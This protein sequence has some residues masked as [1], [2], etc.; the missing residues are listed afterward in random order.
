MKEEMKLMRKQGMSYQEIGQVCGVSKDIVR[1]HLIKKVRLSHKIIARRWQEKNMNKIKIRKRN[2]KYQEYNNQYIKDRYHSDPEFRKKF[3]QI[4]KKSQKK[5]KRI[6]TKKG[7]CLKCGKKKDK[8]FVKCGKC[9]KKL[10]LREV[11]K[12]QKK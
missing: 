8:R 2:K 11:E 6:R 9:R 5:S 4:V 10:R 7:L 3:I 1:Y 12:C